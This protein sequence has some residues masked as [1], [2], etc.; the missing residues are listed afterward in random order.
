MAAGREDPAIE[1][2]I[3]PRWHGQWAVLDVAGE[4]D[5]HTASRLRESIRNE[6]DRGRYQVIVNLEGVSF[7]DSSGLG[8]LVS[9]LKRIREHD[10]E[11]HLVF[12]QRTI[13]RVMEVTGLD[14]VIPLHP[15]E[16]E[17]MAT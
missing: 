5:A 17:A 2:E 3:R 9:A 11:L 16:A 13:V 8:V 6:L 4:I 14:K 12:S 10:G 15:N 7:M 1:L